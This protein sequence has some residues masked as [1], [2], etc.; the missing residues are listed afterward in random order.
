M[1]TEYFA[2]KSPQSCQVSVLAQF[3]RFMFWAPGLGFVDRLLGPTE[4]FQGLPIAAATVKRVII[5]S[6]GLKQDHHSAIVTA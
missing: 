1:N 2:A 3:S 5:A 6:A 4:A